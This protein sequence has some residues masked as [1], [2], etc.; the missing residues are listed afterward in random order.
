[1]STRP[2]HK[3]E[4][5]AIYRRAPA[6]AGQNIQSEADLRLPHPQLLALARALARVMAAGQDLTNP[7]T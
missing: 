1:M 5:S 3:S 6:L 2:K 7:E 4:A